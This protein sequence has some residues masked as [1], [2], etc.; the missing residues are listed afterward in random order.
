MRRVELSTMLKVSVEFAVSVAAVV[1]TCWIILPDVSTRTRSALPV[2]RT[3]GLD[4]SVPIAKLPAKAA[5]EYAEPPV[6]KTPTA[7]PDAFWVIL[8]KLAWVVEVLVFVKLAM[9][10][11][12]PPDVVSTSSL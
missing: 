9:N 5:V 6:P 2:I 3:S 7:A 1:L 4:P 11:V 10:G 8:I 12:T